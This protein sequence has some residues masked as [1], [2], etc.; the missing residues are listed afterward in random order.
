MI[1]NLFNPSISGLKAGIELNL[2]RKCAN[3]FN[4]N[5]SM[6]SARGWYVTTASNQIDQNVLV[7]FTAS[8]NIVL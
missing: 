6:Y 7:T 8:S 5:C 3:T 4:K 2:F 1:S